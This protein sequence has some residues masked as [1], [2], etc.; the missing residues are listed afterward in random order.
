MA[1]ALFYIMLF[2][3]FSLII[4]LLM[5]KSIIS[6]LKQSVE[7][8]NTVYGLANKTVVLKNIELF[9]TRDLYFENMEKN[10][11]YIFTGNGL[12]YIEVPSYV[13][14]YLGYPIGSFKVN[15]SFHNITLY[16]TLNTYNIVG[17]NLDI[18]VKH[19]RCLYIFRSTIKNNETVI[20]ID[21]P[22]RYYGAYTIYLRGF[23]CTGNNNIV[24]M[25]INIYLIKD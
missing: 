5:I 15:E 21:P 9:I 13:P 12:E 19:N 22:K 18:I 23:I 20:R 17:Y 10:S 6:G 24:Y 1:K 16:I 2:T 4:G 14:D 7:D 25:R 3:V 8:I 11:Y